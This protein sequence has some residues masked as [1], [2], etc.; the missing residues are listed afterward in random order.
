VKSVVTTGSKIRDCISDVTASKIDIGAFGTAAS[1]AD[2]GC[3]PVRFRGLYHRGMVR[4]QAC[5]AKIVDRGAEF[6][7]SSME[8]CDEP[9]GPFRLWVA[10]V[11]WVCDGAR[12]DD[13]I[14]LP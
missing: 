3:M 2:A 11:Q 12:D 1:I 8:L 10:R 7:K 13:P 4:A 14:F 6:S 5:C 9:F